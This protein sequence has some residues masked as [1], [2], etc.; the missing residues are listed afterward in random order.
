M[1]SCYNLSIVKNLSSKKIFLLFLL[2]PASFFTFSLNFSL[3]ESEQEIKEKIA[4][5][6]AE[7]K[8]L[9][10]AIA[11]SEKKV[12]E[13]A[14]QS[15]SLKKEIA[16]LN[17]LNSKLKKVIYQKNREIEKL[18]KE[19]KNLSENIAENT[20]KIE[21]L[22]KN[23]KLNLFYLNQVSNRSLF[24]TLLAGKNIS[25][26]A[27]EAARLEKIQNIFTENIK[28]YKKVLAELESTK[29]IK[30]D[31][32][33][34]LDQE[35]ENL[36]DKKLILEQNKKNKDYLLRV[37]KNKEENFKKL[38]AEQIKAKKEF[39]EELFKLESK[40]KFALDKSTVPPEKVGLFF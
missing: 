37:T 40:L 36:A 11:E 31:K 3:A 10:K 39:E 22:K 38:L 13:Y 23:L 32:N 25:E 18:N 27:E 14:G 12:K 8:R 26:V 30:E 33:K 5:Q 1:S 6:D 21:K 28:R 7:I 16:N 2:I 15:A 24:E 17:Y 9:E 29:K 35:K 4:Q 19:I 20:Q 34:K